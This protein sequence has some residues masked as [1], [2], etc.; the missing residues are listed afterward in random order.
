[1]TGSISSWVTVAL[2]LI[3]AY[4]WGRL[5]KFLRDAWITRF[6]SLS[7]ILGLAFLNAIGGLLNLFGWATARTLFGL[8]LG[9]VVLAAVDALRGAGRGGL[10]VVAWPARVKT[11]APVLLAL[12]GG[13]EACDLLVPTTFFN[14][15]DDLNTYIPRSVR[16]VQ[17]GSVAGSPFDAIGLDSLGSQ[18]FF[19]GF[20]LHASRID[21]LNGFDS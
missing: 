10:S 20:F 13:A 7:L 2:F 17:T 21:W 12:F 1:M 15:G 11:L 18:S 9:G 8:V 19:H 4:G 14:A 6:H 3:S 5:C 16:M